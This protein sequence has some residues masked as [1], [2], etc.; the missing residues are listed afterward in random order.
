VPA[1]EWTNVE[2]LPD[3]LSTFKYRS[4]W[5]TDLKDAK[6]VDSVVIEPLSKEAKA[7]RS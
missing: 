3:S 2:D 5:L 1:K 7:L 6:V 4:A